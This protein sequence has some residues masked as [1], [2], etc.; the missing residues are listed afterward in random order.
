MESVLS[1]GG[2]IFHYTA[3]KLKHRN[4]EM[5]MVARRPTA[6]LLIIAL[7]IPD[8]FANLNNA[9]AFKKVG[10]WSGTLPQAEFDAAHSRSLWKGR[11]L[12][13]RTTLTIA[14]YIS[15]RA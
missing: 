10:I 9:P 14:E 5:G 6:Y 1:G 12:F 13:S 15:F 3:N 4:G 2:D 11:R 7:F 8:R